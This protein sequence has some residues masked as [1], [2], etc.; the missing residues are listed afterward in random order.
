MEPGR[1]WAASFLLGAGLLGLLAAIFHL[2]GA[3][4]ILATAGY[5]WVAIAVLISLAGRYWANSDTGPR[6][7]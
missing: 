1:L 2:S 3:A 6:Q 5:V 4:S 7:G